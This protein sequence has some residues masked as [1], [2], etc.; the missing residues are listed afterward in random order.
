MSRPLQLELELRGLG[1][2][3][4]SDKM[5]TRPRPVPSRVE[6]DASFSHVWA[7]S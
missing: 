5:L 1:A 2:R 7:G 6:P 4:V 3:P